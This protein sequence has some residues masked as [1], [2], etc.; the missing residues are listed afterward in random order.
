VQRRVVLL[1]ALAVQTAQESREI[2]SAF[3]GEL[4]VEHEHATLVVIGLNLGNDRVQGSQQDLFD[5]ILVVE[6]HRPVD[7]TRVVLVRIA[8]VDDLVGVDPIGEFTAQQ[9][10]ERVGRYTFQVHVFAIRERQYA[11]LAEVTGEIRVRDAAMDR[12]FDVRLGFGPASLHGELRVH[13]RARAQR[14]GYRRRVDAE[15]VR[16]ARS[17]QYRDLVR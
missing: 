3:P 11:R 10:G 14:L 7:V 8:T 16:L 4:T 15:T 1:V 6:I 17:L 13:Q 9:R 2:R 12:P 5:E